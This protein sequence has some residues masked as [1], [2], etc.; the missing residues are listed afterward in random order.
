M[1]VIAKLNYLR[2]APR[3]VRLVAD[4]IRGKTTAEAERILRFTR[5]RAARPLLKLLQSAI[6]NAKN[7]FQLDPDNLRIA[8]LLVNQGPT[9]K[10]WRPRARGQASQIQKKS[11]HITLVLEEI[12]KGKKRTKKKPA[13]KR[14]P[15]IV[16]KP[17]GLEVKAKAKKKDEMK[18]PRLIERKAKRPSIPRGIKKV[19]QRKAFG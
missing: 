2:I 3:K 8:K 12:E 1:E 6:A 19:F 14:K 10:R 9:L 7:N 16:K 17:K 5:K 18:E 13:T 15:Q 11:S 4:L